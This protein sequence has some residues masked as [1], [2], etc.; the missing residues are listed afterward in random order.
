M[1]DIRIRRYLTSDVDAIYDA[2]I[3]SKAELQRWMPWCHADYSREDTVQWVLG[4]E[5][6]WNRKDEFD[7]VI[8]SGDGRLLG[9]CGIKR[10]EWMNRCAEVGY[11]VRTSATCQGI[12]T[13][14]TRQ[15]CQWAFEETDL[16]R[17]EILA[18]IENPASIRVAQKAGAVREG[19]LRQ[20]LMLQG[21]WHDCVLSAVLNES[22]GD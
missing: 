8:E 16:H 3:E 4:R 9:T 11:W 12:A 6:A 22:G 19:I 14:A 1:N 20:R 7:F 5:E 15:L 13:D 10:F 18:S 2:V 17:L 21:R